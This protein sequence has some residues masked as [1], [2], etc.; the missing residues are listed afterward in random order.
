MNNK[1]RDNV[2]NRPVK[3]TVPDSSL[4]RTDVEVRELVISLKERIFLDH[5]LEQLLF[6]ICKDIP[7]NDNPTED[8]SHFRLQFMME[9]SKYGGAFNDCCEWLGPINKFNYCPAIKVHL[10]NTYEPWITYASNVLAYLFGKIPGCDSP[11][12]FLK[13][14]A[15]KANE[16]FQMSCGNRKCIRISHIVYKEGM[17]GYSV[18]ERVNPYPDYVDIDEAMKPSME[19]ID[20]NGVNGSYIQ[21]DQNTYQGSSP[22]D[23]VVAQLHY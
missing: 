15:I 2:N 11:S 21:N 7:R 16:P 14:S 23:S 18:S 10:P 9:P 4:R 1:A 8:A 22:Q 13:M 3:I 17:K 20:M 19:A 12:S 5:E 6:S